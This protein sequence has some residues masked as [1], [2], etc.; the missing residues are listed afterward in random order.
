[1]DVVIE[2][3]FGDIELAKVKAFSIIERTKIVKLLGMLF[4]K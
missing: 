2:E 3:A 4:W 1:M